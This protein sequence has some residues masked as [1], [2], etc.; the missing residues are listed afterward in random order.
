MKK[1]EIHLWDVQRILFGQAP[2]EFLLE[3]L[4]RTLIIYVATLIVIRLL[5][6]RMSG[7]ISIIEMAVFITLGAIVSLPMQAPDRGILQG[8]LALGCALVFQRG[9]N[10]LGFRSEKV[11]KLAQGDVTLLV[12]DGVL[13]LNEMKKSAVSR[14]Q[15]FAALRNKKIYNLGRVKCM[16]LEGCGLFSIYEENGLRPGLPVLPPGDKEVLSTQRHLPGGKVVCINCGTVQPEENRQKPYCTH[17]GN[18]E[19]E[20]AIV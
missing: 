4:I 8:L 19:M 18:N 9:L 14:Q 7:Q 16:Y 1:E 10:L 3:V 20:Q 17:C 11:E 13:L 12:K 6:K 2:P 15:L 5:G